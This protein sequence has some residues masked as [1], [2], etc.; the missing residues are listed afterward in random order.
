MF[1]TQLALIICAIASIWIIYILSSEQNKISREILNENMKMD[2]LATR[3]FIALENPFLETN[4]NSLIQVVVIIKNVVNHLHII[5]GNV[6]LLKQ[7]VV[8]FMLK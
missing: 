2:T 1:Y 6:H 7:I 8:N 3:A 5:F 4:V